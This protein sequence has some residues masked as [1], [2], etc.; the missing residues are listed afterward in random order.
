[1]ACYNGSMSKLFNYKRVIFP[2]GKQRDFLVSA[3][4]KLNLTA[5][6]FVELLKISVRTFTDWKRE[7]YSISLFALEEICQI[8]KTSLPKDIEVKDA[9]WYTLKGGI[10]GGQAVYKKYGKIGGDENYRKSQWREWWETQGKYEKHPIIGVR[11]KIKKPKYSRALAEFVGILLGDGGL[12]KYQL[13]IT[14]N[15]KEKAYIAYQ[16]KLIK[17]IFGVSPSEHL[18]NNSHIN[19]EV[20]RKNLVDFCKEITGLSP[21]DK[22]KQGLDIPLWIKNNVRYQKYCLRGLIDTDGSLFYER[23]KIGEKIYQYPR[24]NFVSY[25]PALIKSVFDVF[26]NLGFH[27]VVRRNNLAVQIENYQEIKRYFKFIGSHNWEKINKEFG[28]LRRMVRHQS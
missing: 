4:K 2:K 7:K 18:R 1:M 14:T 13:K 15:V 6:S 10:A 27:P 9:F 5:C 16:K 11:K 3:Q 12:S 28:G 8:L 21:G 19:I 25:S 20:S 17:K 23:H 24:L 26:H 22:L